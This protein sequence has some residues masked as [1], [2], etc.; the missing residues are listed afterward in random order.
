MAELPHP[1]TERVLVAVYDD[2]CL[3]LVVVILHAV[4]WVAAPPVPEVEV[5]E[6]AVRL[7]PAGS[8][9]VGVVVEVV[10]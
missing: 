5:T 7:W 10:P 2:D 9:V 3:V 6:S 1:V 4:H 8:Q